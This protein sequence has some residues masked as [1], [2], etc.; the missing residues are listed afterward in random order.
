VSDAGHCFGD[1]CFVATVDDD[2]NA[3]GRKQFG[4]REPDTSGTADDDRAAPR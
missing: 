3:K 1:G 2:A 4:Y